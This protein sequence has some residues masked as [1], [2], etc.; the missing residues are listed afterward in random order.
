M[1]NVSEKKLKLLYLA[2][3]LL[4]K[5]DEGHAVTLPQML[6]EL[7][8]HGLHAERKSLYDDLETLRHFGFPIETRKTRTFEYYLGERRFSSGELALLADA[9][10]QAPFLSQKK[11]AQLI[12]K[13]A[14][15]GSRFQAEELLR[16]QKEEPSG[17]EEPQAREPKAPGSGKEESLTTE[18][19]VRW[20]MERDVQVIFQTAAWK[21]SP[22]GT[23][24][25]ASQT[26]TVSPW[27]LSRR[28]GVTSLLA[29]DG[30][31]KRLRR[32]P[33]E[34]MKQVQLLSQPREGEKALPDLEKLT[35]EF[36]QELLPQVAARFEGAL[37]VEQQG[38]GKLRASVKASVEP[39]LFGWLFQMGG[40]VKLVG[41]KKLAEQL[42]ERAKALAKSY[43]S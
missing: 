39:A 13:L 40:E 41:P 18:E 25:R 3:M 2:Q 30:E 22:S 9:V 4:E 16:S 29:Y 27:Q 10:R 20:A 23:M 7:E 34:E 14:A 42:R 1:P 33:L 11:G 6:E 43:K 5:T 37:V 36:S 26:V 12:K 21:L 15:L 8:S 28:E 19:L 32:F 35:L 31:E 17:Q 38:K 24:K